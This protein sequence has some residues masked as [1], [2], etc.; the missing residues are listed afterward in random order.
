LNQ[1]R[2]GV[3]IKGDE[4][5]VKDDADSVRKQLEEVQI[6][7]EDDVSRR[8]CGSPVSFCIIL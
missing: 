1:S 3:P 5:L 6:G 4:A 8:S 2:Q 7:L